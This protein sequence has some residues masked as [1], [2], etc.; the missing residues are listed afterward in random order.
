MQH[1]LVAATQ[2]LGAPLLMAELRA[3]H[4]TCSVTIDAAPASARLLAQRQSLAPGQSCIRGSCAASA[5]M[6][7][8]PRP[9]APGRSS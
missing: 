1:Q 6:A 5:Y 9:A 7:G 8:Q 3:C 2:A 4:A